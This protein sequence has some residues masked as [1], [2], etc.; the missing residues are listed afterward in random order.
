CSSPRPFGL[1]A[2]AIRDPPWESTFHGTWGPRHGPRTPPFFAP[3]LARSGSAPLRSDVGVDISRDLGASFW[4]P[5]SPFFPPPPAR[6]ARRLCDPTWESTF[7]G[8]W[9][10]RHGPRTPPFLLLAS[11]VRARRLCDPPWEST[12]N[13]TSR[14]AFRG[15]P[16]RLRGR[17]PWCSC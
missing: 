4:R 6:P 16:A 13:G 1:G 7:H 9:G 5:H 14:D 3:R 17:R 8:T 10:L 12:S 11:P 2:S 15:R